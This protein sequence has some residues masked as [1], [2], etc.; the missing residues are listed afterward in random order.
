M[1]AMSLDVK[2]I[3]TRLNLSQKALAERLSVDQATISRI[4]SGRQEPSGPVALLLQALVC[5]TAKGAEH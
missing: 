5:D 1:G 4:E 2:S 3:R